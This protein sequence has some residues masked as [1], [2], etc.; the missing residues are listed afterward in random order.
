MRLCS[1]CL[2]GINCG[3]NAGSKPNRAV[4]ALFK[5]EVLIPICPEQ[6]GSR[7]TPREQTEVIEGR[8]ITKS[9]KDVTKAFKKG[10]LEVLKIAKMHN[11]SQVILKQRSPLC[12]SGKIYDGTFSGTLIK[13]DGI[14]T[15]CLK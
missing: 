7:P 15:H 13:G 11:I 1:A 2:V 12:A 5:K 3:Y 8:A 4:I 14:T 10:A 6:L 9:G